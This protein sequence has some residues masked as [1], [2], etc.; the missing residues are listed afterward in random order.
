MHCIQFWYFVSL[1][2]LFLM[3]ISNFIILFSAQIGFIRSVIIIYVSF[4]IGLR[5]WMIS[6][7]LPLVQRN[8]FCCFGIFFWYCN[9]ANILFGYWQGMKLLPTGRKNS[10]AIFIYSSAVGIKLKSLTPSFRWKRLF[11]YNCF[12]QVGLGSFFLRYLPGLCR[13]ILMEIGISEDMYY[14]VCKSAV[15]RE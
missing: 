5:L 7:S 14:P 13:T 10:L 8:Y 2:S 1:L 9:M 6:L 3:P 11:K 4:F 15:K 12:C